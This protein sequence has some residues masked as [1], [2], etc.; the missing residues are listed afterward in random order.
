VVLENSGD[1]IDEKDKVSFWFLF[2]LIYFFF[3]FFRIHFYQV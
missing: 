2:V 1:G 3:G